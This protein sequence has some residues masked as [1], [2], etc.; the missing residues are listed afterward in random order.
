MSDPIKALSRV[1]Q[2]V[3]RG[4]YEPVP[5]LGRRD[6]LGQ[7]ARS[8]AEMIGDL[9]STTVSKAYVESILASMLDGLLVVD[10]AGAIV[11]ANPACCRL[12]GRPVDALA[13]MPIVAFL[14]R[15]QDRYAGSAGEAPR[16]VSAEDTLRAENGALPVLVSCAPLSGT[17]SSGGRVVVLRDI[18]ALKRAEDA[19]ARAKAA[20]EESSRSKSVFLANMS[21]ELRTPLN[22]IIGFSDVMHNE[23]LGALGTPRYREYAR[24]IYDSG[25]H[26]LR[27][28]NDIL[29]LAR[30]EAGKATLYD[31]VFGP[32]EVIDEALRLIAAR[33]AEQGLATDVQLAAGLP[34][35]QA[36]R[37]MVRQILLNLLSNAVK[38]TPPGGRIV[39][40]AARLPEGGLAI[41]VADTGIGI[42]PESIGKVL[43]PFGQIDD[44]LDRSYEG[45]GLGLP[46]V[47]SLAE[48]HGGT[49]RLESHVGAG[50]T[51]TVTFPPVRAIARE[52][53]AA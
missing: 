22:A 35:L 14:E 12:L 53:T 3:G 34:A 18:A 42:A 51:A 44:G 48:L 19:M 23:V 27:I 25:Q 13:G 5:S 49:F 32:D 39:V 40:R 7:L 24:D 37:R 8:M 29:D 20:A 21:H 46:I 43:T 36:D 11:T 30:I 4:N 38:F 41:S 47:K 50:T 33:A 26:L 16:P 10:G 6:E 9:R 31:E 1:A 2:Q 15:W 52:A 45:T 17:G 28:V